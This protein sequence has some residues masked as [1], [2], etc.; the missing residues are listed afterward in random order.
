MQHEQDPSVYIARINLSDLMGDVIDGLMNDAADREKFVMATDLA[1]EVREEKRKRGKYGE[2]PSAIRRKNGEYR[3]T[4]SVNSVSDYKKLREKHDLRKDLRDKYC[5]MKIEE[6]LRDYHNKKN[7]PAKEDR[8]WLRDEIFL[9]VFFLIPHAIKKSCRIATCLFNDAVQ[10]VSCE[11]LRAIDLFDPTKGFTFVNY[12]VG[13]IRSGITR[14]FNDTNVVAVQ[15]GRRRILKEQQELH[16]NNGNVTGPTRQTVYCNTWETQPEPGCGSE[17]TSYTGLEYSEN[18]AFG[19]EF[20]FDKN[21]HDRQMVQFL[22]FALNPAYGIIDYDER[23]V[24]VHHYAVFGAPKLPY[25]DI[26]AMRAK[27]GRGSAYSRLSQIHT[28]ALRKLK[29]FFEENG[30]ELE[31]A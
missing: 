16:A 10:N 2:T 29:E 30:I 25:K 27:E 22:R 20:D 4:D 5:N 26:A 19:K 1:Q 21:L 12:L 7:P 15:S 9:R 11:V 28:Q 23:R 31:F 6:L 3:F 18:S 24:L 13:Y 14:T 17:I 8:K